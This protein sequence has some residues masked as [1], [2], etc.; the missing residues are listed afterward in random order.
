MA[1]ERPH[2]ADG[3]AAARSGLGQLAGPLDEL[4]LACTKTAFSLKTTTVIRVRGAGREPKPRGRPSMTRKAI[5]L[6][7]MSFAVCAV[8]TAAL[9]VS[10]RTEGAAERDVKA[11]VR[12]MDKD[13]NG[14][15]SK[16]EFL[17]FMGQVFDR[18]DVDKN[19]VLEPK[20]LQQS[21]IPRAILR[22]CVHRAFPECSGG[23]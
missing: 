5:V 22:D 6:I 23:N 9:A 4:S 2:L 13:Q 16:D 3:V 14:T 7:A 18:V 19:G 10:K 8:S 20:E 11:L 17:Q 1:A 15:V 12:M 21:V